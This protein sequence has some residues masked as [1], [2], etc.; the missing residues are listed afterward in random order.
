[1]VFCDK[2]ARAEKVW[3]GSTNW[4]VTGLCTQ[5]NNGI[6]ID[7]ATIAKAYK[8]RWDALMKVKAAYPKSLAVAGSKPAVNS[9]NGKAIRAWN[10]P[11]LKYADLKEAKRYIDDAEQGVIYLMFNPGKG[12]GKKKAKALI[13]DILALDR[14]KIFIEGILNQDPGGKKDPIIQLTH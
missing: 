12:D 8:N 6:L 13:Q 7:D 4:T 9:L 5:T 10:V 2:Q 14:N 1:M 11:C 3:T